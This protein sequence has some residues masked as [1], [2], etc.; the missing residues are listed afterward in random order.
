MHEFT[1][2]IPV[3]NEHDLLVEAI[4][5]V[6]VSTMRPNRVIIVDNGDLPWAPSRDFHAQHGLHIARPQRNIG[7]AGA[8]N[9]I[10]KLAAPLTTIIIN[11]D[12]RVL[13]DTFEKMMEYPQPHIV[14]AYGFGCFRMDEAIWNSVG[15]FDEGFYPVYF[16]DTD[17][18]YRLKLAGAPFIE[19]D[20]VLTG[21]KHGKDQ[22]DGYQGWRGE[23]LAWFHDCLE[24]NHRRYVEKWGG[25]HTKE[26]FTIPFDGK[27][28]QCT[29]S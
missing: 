26:T 21:I 13:P 17:Y 28:D 4:E 22:P 23:K 10:H 12:C 5:A 24:K 14:A 7:C 1:V 6:S 8:W 3:V 11:A 18:R 9:L 27:A 19:W 16:E 20:H 29:S 15:P 25:E 2:G